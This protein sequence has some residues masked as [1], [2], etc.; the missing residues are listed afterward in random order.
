MIS[1]NEALQVVYDNIGVVGTE[2]ISVFESMNRV[3]VA[4]VSS[5]RSLPPLDNSAMDGYAV[6]SADLKTPPFALKVLGNIAAG[7]NVKG[8]KISKGECYRIMTGAFIPEG[9]D[10]VIQHEDTDN[11]LDI[12]TVNKEIK[13][14]GN[15]RKS[16]ED[17]KCGDIVD[18]VGEKITAYHISRLVSAGVF[19]ISVYRLPKIAVISTGNEIATPAELDNPLKTYD[20]NGQAMKYLLQGA[21]ADVTYL[22]VI[23]DDEKALMEC[24]TKLKGFDMIVTSAGISVGDF[25]LMNIIASKLG[26]KW[27]FNVVNQKPGKHIAFGEVFGI[28]IFATPG[29]PVSSTFCTYFYVLPAARMLGGN[30]H[31]RNIPIN[32]K[33]GE[34]IARKKGRVQFDRVKVIVENGE[35]VAY[36]FSNQDSHRIASIVEGNAFSCLNDSQ[37]GDIPKGSTIPV[38]LFNVNQVVR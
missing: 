10:T 35:F 25:D 17:I 6:N 26:I 30:K 23:P 32:A 31:F 37:I 4:N 2:Y 7:D 14:H 12:V 15:V 18:M 24:F 27:K 9:A 20:S 38:Y 5:T 36:P 28:P 33:L 21:P 29:N 1:A 11:K 19:Y 22:G 34:T 3:I 16:G 8:L 13:A